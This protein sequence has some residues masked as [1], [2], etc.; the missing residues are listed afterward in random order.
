[1]PNNIKSLELIGYQKTN[2]ERVFPEKSADF[3]GSKA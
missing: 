3:V 1:M 2:D